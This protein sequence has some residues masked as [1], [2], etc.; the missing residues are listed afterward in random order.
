MP[1]KYSSSANAGVISWTVKKLIGGTIKL[2]FKV[3]S[4]KLIEMQIEKL[5]HYLQKHPQYKAYAI[6]RIKQE[7]NKHPKYKK[8][9]YILLNRVIKIANDKLKIK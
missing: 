8:R 1:Y 7:I 3:S 5:V 9:G 6:K 2:V 4:E